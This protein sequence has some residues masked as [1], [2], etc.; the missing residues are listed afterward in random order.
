MTSRMVM[1]ALLTAMAASTLAGCN[2][3]RDPCFQGWGEADMILVSPDESG[4]VIKLVDR[5][6]HRVL[7]IFRAAPGGGGRIAPIEKKEVGR[8]L[9]IP[10]G[11]GG[12]ARD[13]D[14]V[15]V[16][17][18]QALTVLR[19]GRRGTHPQQKRRERYCY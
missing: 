11:A 8:E 10:P 5:G 14:L 13:G 6:R 7:G 9:A 1:G 15:P 16:D 17:H 4:R 19:R 18:L 3:R 2:E 12:E